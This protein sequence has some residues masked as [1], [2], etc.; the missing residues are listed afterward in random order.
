MPLQCVWCQET[1]VAT[2][3]C[4]SFGDVARGGWSLLWV[5]EGRWRASIDASSR[6]CEEACQGGQQRTILWFLYI[7]TR[8]NHI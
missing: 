7:Y 1:T 3:G 6:R 5:S 8:N 2:S 4:R